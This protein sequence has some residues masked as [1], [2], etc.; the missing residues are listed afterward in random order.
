MED[1]L[2]P[3]NLFLSSNNINCNYYLEDDYNNIKS[4][5]KF[6][7]I[8]FNSRSMYANFNAIKEYLQHFVQ[9]FS[10]IALSET[11][12]NDDKGVDFELKD[13]N[14]NYVNRTNKSGGGAALYVHKRFKF[15]VIENMTIAINYILECVSIEII[16]EK[17]KN[18][19]LSCVYRSPGSSLE[20]F[21]K[22][23]L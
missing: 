12:F 14:L 18:F 5:G 13:Y 8:H 1:Q 17:K 9:P 10:I 15:K 16:N 2:D 3:D 20:I 4:E 21:G 6:S 19:I 11:W 22:H 7:I 23:S